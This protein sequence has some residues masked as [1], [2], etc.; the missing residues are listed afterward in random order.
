LEGVPDDVLETLEKGTGDNDGKLRFTFKYPDLFPT[1]KFALDSE[2]R[3]KVF[4][5]NENKVSHKCWNCFG[6][7]NNISATQM[8]LSSR[9]LS[10]SVMKQP[11]FSATQ[12]TPHS[13]SKTRWPRPQRPSMTS[14]VI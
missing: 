8:F 5:E 6:S 14:L 10:F 9:K 3:Q 1:L 11:D 12:I 4:I 13:A 2:T 7:A